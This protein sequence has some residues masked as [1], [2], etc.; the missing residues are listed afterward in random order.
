MMDTDTLTQEQ[1]QGIADFFHYIRTDDTVKLNWGLQCRQIIAN[2]L[3]AGY[4]PDNY[5]TKWLIGARRQILELLTKQCE[6]FNKQFQ[7]DRI[8]SL[9]IVDVL[10]STLKKYG[11]D[12]SQIGVTMSSPQE[13]NKG[14]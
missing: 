5:R 6:E 12:T 7:W 2:A 3:Q 10:L 4:M 1:I 9:D 11:V 14:D 8:S 13:G